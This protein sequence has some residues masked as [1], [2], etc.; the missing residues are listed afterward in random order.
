MSLTPDAWQRITALFDEVH[1]LDGP[2]RQARLRSL[3]ATEPELAAE[4]A[5]L[6]DADSGTDFLDLDAGLGLRLGMPAAHRLIGQSIGAYRVERE[7]GRGGMGVV[8][9]GRHVDRTLHK[10]VAIKTLAIGIDRPELAWRFRRER[11]ILAKLEHP[12]IA[13]LYDGGTTDDGLP[14]LVMEYVD[15][16]RID[17]WC[18]RQRLTI[19]QRLDLFR[20]VCAAVH[21]AH[22]KLIVHRDLK[23]SNIL[24]THDGVVKL[25]D[26]G[27]AKLAVDEELSGELSEYTRAGAA[28]LTTAYA[29][30]EQVRGEEVTTASD[31]YS[32]G[33]ILYRLLTGTSPFVDG[34]T[35]ASARDANA[36][37]Q[38]RTPSDVVTET[39]STQCQLPGVRSL[40]DTLRGELDAIVLMA[41]RAEPER[42]YASADALSSDLLR[43]LRGMPVHARPDTVGYRITKFVGRQRALVAGVSIGLV[44]MVIGTVLA[45]QSARTASAEAARATSMVAFLQSLVGAADVSMFGAMRVSKDITLAELVDSA[46]AQVSKAFPRDPR[47]RADLYASLARSLRRFN[48]YDAALTLVDSAQL[49]HRQ[50]VGDISVD[51]ADD[52]T[53]AAL[54]QNQLDRKSEARRLLT[55]ALERY[56]QLP[57]APPEASTIAKFGMGQ[58]MVQNLGKVADGVQLLTAA[59]AQEANAAVPRRPLIASIEGQR[60]V[61]LASLGQVA[62]SDS[63]F[64][65]ATR[66]FAGDSIRNAEEMATLLANW[67]YMLSSR[68]ENARAVPLMFRAMHLVESTNGPDH[69]MTAVVRTRLANILNSAGDYRRGGAMAD[70]S[71]AIH[72]RLSTQSPSEKSFTLAIRARSAIGAGDLA[73]AEQALARAR[74]LLPQLD[75]DRNER[76]LSLL[77]VESRLFEKRGDLVRARAAAERAA[78]AAAT[79][80]DDKVSAQAV[81]VRLAEIDSLIATKR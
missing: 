47:S 1:A 39:Q 14:Y 16:Q 50:S 30:P 71:L 60:A 44:A 43:Y 58:M 42:R 53:I 35:P 52:M 24:V 51:V 38:V 23:P 62:A 5:S 69:M 64:E 46:G 59:A 77:I 31:V 11:Q 18:D 2:V 78:S 26:F 29:S 68:D 41:L 72:E 19:P 25:L 73:A 49:L 40:R 37:T 4:V 66:I 67:S 32:L 3:A 9:E 75:L 7:V 27:I 56:R 55:G 15:G 28:P 33:V 34:K 74:T 22:A 20:Q 48:R 54:L 63:A 79:F 6:L 8:Y 12:N 21:F 57:D 45:V 36:T 80:G 65:R 13:A 61:G 70:S 81:K 10:R 76:E 17:A